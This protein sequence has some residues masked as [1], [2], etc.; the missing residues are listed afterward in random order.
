[1][2]AAQ[3]PYLW[4]MCPKRTLRD[5]WC[6][7]LSVL[8]LY[9]P[10]ENK[11]RQSLVAIALG[12]LSKKFLIQSHK[13]YTCF[14]SCYS[15]SSYNHVGFGYVVGE[16]LHLLWNTDSMH[17]FHQTFIFRLDDLRPLSSTALKLLGIFLDYQYY[18]TDLCEYPHDRTSVWITQSSNK[19]WNWEL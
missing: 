7:T 15:L 9:S 17:S 14:K 10:H 1:M 19:V 18:S 6:K 11:R 12:V 8:L 13:I 5:R 16:F 3:V 4:T 2:H